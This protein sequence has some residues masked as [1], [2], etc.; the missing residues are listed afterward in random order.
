MT[1]WYY[2]SDSQVIGPV[3][4]PEFKALVDS[5]VIK[6]HTPV[7]T[8]G[9]E[10]WIVANE[11]GV[12]RSRF[13]GKLSSKKA[14]FALLLTFSPFICIGFFMLLA[15]LDIR[16]GDSILRPGIICSLGIFSIIIVFLGFLIWGTVIGSSV[17]D[18]IRKG[19][20][21]GLSYANCATSML[22]L[23]IFSFICS[24]FLILPALGSSR[25]KA[26]RIA[27]GNNLKQIGL[28]LKNYAIDHEGYYPPYSGAMGLEILR[29]GDYLS[30]PKSYICPC[31]IT[32]PVAYGESLNGD[33][34]SYY[35]IGGL[36][37]KP[38]DAEKPVCWDFRDN[39]QK[40][41]VNVLYADGEVK[42]L[43]GKTELLKRAGK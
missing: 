20:T 40:G 41:Y 15:A 12:F 14:F 34:V 8:D 3:N 16:V 37:D 19:W 33:A 28:A 2:I 11:A 9:M 24:I 5:G 39:H 18:E 35:Y 6:I 42:G 4:G 22:L 25:D 27:C 23:I 21:G 26:K 10:E 36:S 31:C 13:T 32:N 29:E 7:W 43:A 17:K 38:E 30:D 1:K